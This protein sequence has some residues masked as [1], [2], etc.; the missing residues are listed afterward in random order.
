MAKQT[1]YL[2]L[3]TETTMKNGL[4]FDA[5]FELFDRSGNTYEYGSYLFSD[6][7]AIEEPFY[8]DKIA[9][10]WALAFK[11][12][13]RPIRFRTFRK[14][15]ND[16]LMRYLPSYKIVICAYNAKFDIDHIGKNCKHLLDGAQF[17][18]EKTKNVMFLD[19]WHAWVQGC[20]VDYGYFA[21]FSDKGNLRTN[22]EN[23]YRYISEHHNFEE[24]HIAHSDI[25]IEKVILMDILRRKKKLPLV[26]NP[27]DFVAMPWKLAQERCKV[28]IADR[29]KKQALM[30]PVLE[31]IPDL[32]TRKGHMTDEPTIVFPRN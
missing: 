19:L 8:K 23:V 11:G 6:V 5:A 26:S 20:P 16:L 28:P 31:S 14:I 29:K 9:Q 12:K 2:M 18:N 27:K 4:V 22:A 10:Y 30:A 15:F 7:L 32:T 25:V 21:P 13:V 3:D 1:L 24:K 17:L